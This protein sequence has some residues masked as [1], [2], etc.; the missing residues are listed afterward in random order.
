M[1]TDIERLQQGESLNKQDVRIN[2]FWEFGKFTSKDEESIESYY[3][4]FYKMMNEMV[5]NKLEVAT[6]QVYVKFLQQLQPKWSRFV[7]VVKQIVDLDK[8]SNANPLA[9]IAAA[10]HYP[11]YHN[12]APK[13]HKSIAP[14][15]RQITSS[16]S[17]ATTKSKGKEVVKQP[18][19]HLSQH[20]KKTVM[21]N[22]LR[23]IS[24]FRKVWLLL[25]STSRTSTNLPTTTSELHQ[26]PGTSTWILVQGLGMTEILGNLNL[27]IWLKNEEN[28]K[29]R[30]YAYHKEKM[31]LCKQ[32]EKGV[33]LSAE[34]G[35]WLDDIDEELD[36]QE[37]EA[38]YLLMEKIQEEHTD[39]P[40]NMNDTS[41]IEKVYSN[42]TLDSSDV[43]NNDFEDDHNA[44]NQEDERVALANL[45]TNLKLDTDENK[46]IQKQLK[47]ANTS[48][49][50][51][52]N[53]CKYAL[54]ESNNI[55]DR[56]RN[57]K[58]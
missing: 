53:E 33:P 32:A 18:H 25:Q 44:D 13:P 52:L 21:K 26:T 11:E 14:S 42:T 45:T 56:C 8:E 6:M 5:R 49:T 37:L 41:L 22:M 34:Q 1:W 2:L 47:R 57:V 28:Q 23:G 29:G 15:S 38:H 17:H 46:K 58:T 30:D 4:R 43:C 54:A 40:E 55:H 50:H 12:Q 48:L 19:H 16:K 24:K 9:L 27:G 35:E 39:Q 31:L 3:S 36:E 51:E 7:T 20:L 10:Q